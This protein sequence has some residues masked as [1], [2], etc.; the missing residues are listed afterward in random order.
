LKKASPSR[1][2]IRQHFS[3]VR[4][5]TGAGGRGCAFRAHR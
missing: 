5:R 2:V 1:G 3:A 4:L